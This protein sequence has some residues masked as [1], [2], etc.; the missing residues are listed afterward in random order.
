MFIFE[1][2]DKAT[3]IIFCACFSLKVRMQIFQLLSPGCIGGMMIQEPGDCK[4]LQLTKL[5]GVGPVYNRPS[6]AELHHFVQK[7]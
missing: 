2:R 3:S 1:D 4:M 7:K 6:P 5:D